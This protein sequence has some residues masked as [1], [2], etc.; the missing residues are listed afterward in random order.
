MSIEEEKREQFKQ[1]LASHTTWSRGFFMLLF[2]IIGYFLFCYVIIIL[3]LFQFGTILITGRVNQRVSPIGDN[4]STY[5]YQ[6]LLYLTYSSDERPFPFSSWPTSEYEEEE[7]IVNL[8]EES[9]LPP[10]N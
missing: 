3:V 2:A 1:N 9:E 4:L 8:T 10:K 7:S 5:I 6:I